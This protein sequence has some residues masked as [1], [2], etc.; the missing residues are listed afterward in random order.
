M[1]DTLKETLR[2]RR[3]EYVARLLELASLDTA[4]VGHG[5]EGGGEETGQLWMEALLREMGAETVREPLT[6]EIIQ[7]GLARFGEGNPGHVYSGDGF[8]R[9]N[10]IGRFK[11]GEGRSL[12]FDGHIDTMPSGPRELWSFDPLDAQV[13]DGKIWGLGTCDMKGGL[14]AS[15]LGVKLLQDAGIPLPGDVRILSVVDEEGGGNGS[16]AAMLAGHG[17]DAAVVCEPSDGSVTV[18]HMGFVF[19]QVEVRGVALHSGSK[20]KGVNAIEKAVLLMGAL[21]DLEH[22]W[23]MRYKHPMLPP[24]NLNVGVIE[25]GTAGSTVPD[26]CVFKLCLHYHPETMSHDSVVKEVTE[27]LL[28]RAAGDPW[29]RDNPPEISVYQAGGAFEMEREHPFVLAVEE[30]IA[31]VRK[32]APPV[33]GSPA[34]NDARL[35]RNI[36]KM[37]VVITGPGRLEQCHSPDEYVEVKDYLD[38]IEIYARLILDW[39]GRHKEERS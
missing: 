9:W 13:R 16:L 3:D 20:W 2:L 38:Y 23:L 5:I 6:E 8:S 34:G 11:G 19:F 22:E 18:A 28:L 27:R 17:A 39:C 33:V 37:P 25:G 32:E 35:L 31:S 29:L 12:L 15:V 24:P 10:L 30:S 7:D 4:V 36:G 14:L 26:R 1:A 21:N